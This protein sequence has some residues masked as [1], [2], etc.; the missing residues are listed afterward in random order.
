ML[1]LEMPIFKILDKIR[2]L[3]A[4]RDN[5]DNLDNLKYFH[6]IDRKTIHNIKKSIIDSSVIRH[7]E[8]ATSVSLRVH[9][10]RSEKYDP[11]LI[12]KKQS[13]IDVFWT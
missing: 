5:R 7:S 2:L 1:S 3:F 10:L 9:A 13:V 8:N 11:V 12:Y 4:S 6:L